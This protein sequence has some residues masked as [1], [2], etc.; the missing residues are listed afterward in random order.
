MRKAVGRS[1]EGDAR[2]RVGADHA[3]PSDPHQPHYREGLTDSNDPK[4]G[5]I[6]NVSGAALLYSVTHADQRQ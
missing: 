1:V 5:D 4:R 6:F 3:L 2:V